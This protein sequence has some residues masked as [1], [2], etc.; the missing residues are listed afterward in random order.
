MKK[1]MYIEG[2]MCM[3]CVKRAE[4]A[5]NA[6]EGVQAKVDLES[7]TAYIEVA[8]NISDLALK[9]AVEKQ[10]YQVISIK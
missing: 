2:M 5:L 1:E 8:E 6:L 10:G 3:H 7:K 4:D 9:N